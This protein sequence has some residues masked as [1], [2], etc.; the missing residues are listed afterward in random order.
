MTQWN[1]QS[2]WIQ[3]PHYN[4]SKMGQFLAE[5]QDVGPQ[6][7]WKWIRYTRSSRG[8]DHKYKKNV[9]IRAVYYRTCV[10]VEHLSMAAFDY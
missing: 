5:L 8:L 1:C 9:S 4:T 7:C 10:S 2:T 6:F 3:E